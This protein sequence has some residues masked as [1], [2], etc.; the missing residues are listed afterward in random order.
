LQTGHQTRPDTRRDAVVKRALNPL[1]ELLAEHGDRR[2]LAGR[3]GDCLDS[4]IDR[5]ELGL[6]RLSEPRVV[7]RLAQDQP[8]PLL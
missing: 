4:P 5:R 6:E 1:A 7:D 2:E 8:P 3:L